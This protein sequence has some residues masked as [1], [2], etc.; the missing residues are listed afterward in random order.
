MAEPARFK[1]FWAE[2]LPGRDDVLRLLADGGCEVVAGRPFADAARPFGDEELV[3]ILRDVDGVMVGSRER[4]GRRIFEACP[5]LVTVAKLGIGV[6]RI[7]VAAATE[8]GILVSN[9]PLPENYLSV[10]EQAVGAILAF[11]KNF[12]AADRAARERRWRGVTNSLVKGKTVGIVGVGRIGSRVAALL[13]PF[14]VRLLGYDP[15]VPDARLRALGVEPAALEAL[16]AGSDFVTVHAV[17]TAQNVGMLGAREFRRMKPTAYFVNTARG[18]LVDEA[19][20]TRALREG[21]IAGA[22]LDV[23][24]P[25]PPGAGAAVLDPDLEGRTL[26]SPHVAGV[27]HEAMARMPLAQAENCLRAVRGERPAW[28]VNE[29]VIARWTARRAALGR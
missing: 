20:V 1:V 27:T 14:E 15:F 26:L 23:F 4:W 25:E 19:A 22:A 7:D 2:T 10:A 24:E 6:E 3:R 11:A 16:L 5:R 17:V 8:L 9:T 13:A 12:K 28:V 21:W 18:A 29:D